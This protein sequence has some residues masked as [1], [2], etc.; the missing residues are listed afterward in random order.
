MTLADAEF[1]GRGPKLRF[2]CGAD[3][4]GAR[5]LAAVAEAA[6]LAARGG[7]EIRLDAFRGVFGQ[8]P[9]RPQ[10][11]IVGV[12][13]DAHQSERHRVILTTNYLTSNVELVRNIK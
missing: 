3:D 11:F 12:G 6:A 2:P 5:P 10:R 13:E 7:D 8:R 4:L 9:A 1:L